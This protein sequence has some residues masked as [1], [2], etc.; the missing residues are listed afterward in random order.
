MVSGDYHDEIKQLWEEIYILKGK[1]SDLQ[2]ALGTICS[3]M[4]RISR[5]IDGTAV[6]ADRTIRR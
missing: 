4:H 3:M 1:I 2:F 6:D 5:D